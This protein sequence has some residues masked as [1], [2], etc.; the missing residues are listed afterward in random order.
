MQGE[1]AGTRAAAARP[2]R[3]ANARLDLQSAKKSTSQAN[4]AANINH[5]YGGGAPRGKT[6]G[7]AKPRAV[8]INVTVAVAGLD[9]SSVTDG[10]ETGQFAPAGAPVQV[11]V[12]LL[13]NP[14]AR[15]AETGEFARCPAVILAV[16]CPAGTA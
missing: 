10:G 14:C 8:V 11:H 6:S 5:R 9:P 13:S 16:A 3:C 12:T 7:G 15:A 1:A 4:D 2:G